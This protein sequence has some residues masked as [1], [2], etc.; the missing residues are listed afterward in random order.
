MSEA[1]DAIFR[2]HLEAGRIMLQRSRATGK[3]IFYP[4]VAEP[5]TGCTDFDWVEVSGL[6]TVYSTTVVR[7]RPP[8]PDHNVVLVDLTEG[9]RMMSRVE[10]IAPEAVTI[11]MAVRARIAATDDGPI[12]V[13]DPMEDAA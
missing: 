6:G 10:G 8:T 11:G 3:F 7:Q 1:P 5:E 2:A 9:V 12:I 13:F 4:R